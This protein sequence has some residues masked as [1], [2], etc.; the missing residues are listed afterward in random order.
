MLLTCSTS[1]ANW[2]NKDCAMCYHL[3]VTMRVKDPKLSV[4]RVGHRVPLSGI[5]LSP[6]SLHVLKEDSNMIQTNSTTSCLTS[7]KDVVCNKRPAW[8]MIVEERSFLVGGHHFCWAA[9][10][11]FNNTK[12]F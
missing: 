3:Y 2:F 10:F 9:F 12:T 5:C 8:V 7:K 4:V 6:C 11:Q 1:A